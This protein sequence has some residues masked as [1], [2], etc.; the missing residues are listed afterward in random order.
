MYSL[1]L[2]SIIIPETD[3]SLPKY[4]PGTN[5][6]LKGRFMATEKPRSIKAEFAVSVSQSGG[7][8]RVSPDANVSPIFALVIFI[9]QR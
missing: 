3:F 6:P 1:L 5:A 2:I 7:M 9:G 8:E 4:S